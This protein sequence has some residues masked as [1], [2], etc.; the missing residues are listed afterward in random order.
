METIKVKCPKGKKLEIEKGR[1]T[2]V[3]CPLEC[4]LLKL[5]R[6]SKK[7]FNYTE[8][9]SNLVSVDY[10][11]VNK[12]KSNNNVTN[13]IKVE[14]KK[15][16]FTPYEETDNSNNNDIE[17]VNPFLNMEEET[18]EE[19]N[20][21]NDKEEYS[22]INKYNNMFGVKSIFDDVIIPSPDEPCFVDGIHSFYE[23]YK[24]GSS[25]GVN[26]AIKHLFFH[27]YTSRVFNEDEE[28]LTEEFLVL[29][30]MAGLTKEEQKIK[31]II[32]NGEFNINQKFFHLYYDVI[33]KG[34]MS[35][36]YWSEGECP[37]TKIL[38]KFKDRQDFISKLSK[39]PLFF[40]SVEDCFTEILLYFNKPK[41][42]FFED[43]TIELSKTTKRICFFSETEGRVKLNILGSNADFISELS[44]I[45]TKEKLYLKCEFFKTFTFTMNGNVILR[46]DKFDLLMPKKTEDDSIYQELGIM[47]FGSS[48]CATIYNY[49]TSLLKEYINIFYPRKVIIGNFSYSKDNLLFEF[50]DILSDTCKNL[51]SRGKIPLSSRFYLTK[52]LIERGVF[53]Y[54]IE[55]CETSRLRKVI[56][57]YLMDEPSI[58]DYLAIPDIVHV[59]NTDKGECTVSE[60][61]SA[62]L[63]KDK[64]RTDFNGDV[65][66]Q[67]YFEL[68]VDDNVVNRE[69]KHLDSLIEKNNKLMKKYMKAGDK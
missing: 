35:A 36:F 6:C 66:I 27:W 25:G 22:A 68:N 24:V 62:C 4:Q 1:T 8:I 37:F 56:D 64:I 69:I 2:L 39:N 43:I 11:L 57:F 14:K 38:P 59:F 7:N 30:K 51:T 32:K 40:R 67:S 29:L 33:Y 13:E 53:D 47:H 50:V 46:K 63:D 42:K 45:D 52:S 21:V 31:D 34:Q 41:E 12:E 9:L 48:N 58:K 19:E 18:F 23:R 26:D 10:S 3:T 54:Y 17:F 15:I 61:I 65:I 28:S 20:P 44:Q 49:Y 16:E 60:Y 5:K 55:Q